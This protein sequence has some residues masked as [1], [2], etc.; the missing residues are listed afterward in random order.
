MLSTIAMSDT[1]AAQA[2]HED[3]LQ[4]RTSEEQLPRITASLADIQNWLGTA[5]PRLARLAQLRGVAPDAIDDVVQETLLEAWKHLERLQAPEGFHMWV[6]E[7]CRNV[8]RRYARRLATDQQRYVPLLYPSR[9]TDDENGVAA[10]SSIIDIP[11]E[12]AL[13]PDEVLSRQDLVRLLERALGELPGNAREVVELCYLAELPQREAALRLGLTISALEARLH[14]ARRQL[15]QV[16]S[17]PLRADAESFGLALDPALAEG[18]Q[19]TRIWCSVCGRRMQRGLF[20]PQPDGSVNLHM[21]CPDCLERY[22]LSSIHSMGLVP[23][24]GVRAFRPAWKRI[25]Q[26]MSDRFLQALAQGWFP[27][28]FCGTPASVRVVSTDDQSNLFPSV[29]LQFYKFWIGWQC[30][31]CDDEL[32]VCRLFTADDLVYWSHPQTRQFIQEHPRWISAPDVLME[33][34]GQ[35]AIRFQM[36]DVTSSASLTIIAH[37]QTLSILAIFS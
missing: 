22:D 2:D 36:I 24:D 15:R 31:K 14:R 20:V 4:E 23:L 8:C 26:G 10:A 30:P 19:E 33:Y 21:H 34:A 12:Q 18:W 11:D 25:M 28:P 9:P 3:L 29:C 6:D 7:I 27:C 5:R 13:D 16:L 37:R 32:E 1:I 17:G 35:P